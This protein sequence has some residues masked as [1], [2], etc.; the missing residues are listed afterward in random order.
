M[1][2]AKDGMLILEALRTVMLAAQIKLGKLTS[3]SW[4]LAAMLIR[5]VT[6]ATW[7]LKVPRRLLLL[8]SKVAQVSTSIPSRVLKKVSVIVMDEAVLT[9]ALKASSSSDWRADQLM[10]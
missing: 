9:V 8:M 10:V 6:L 2:V 4:P 5:L 7:V 1:T 3:K